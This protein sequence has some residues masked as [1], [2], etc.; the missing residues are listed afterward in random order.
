MFEEAASHLRE[1]AQDVMGC[2]LHGPP[3]RLERRPG[4]LE[5]D[6][7]IGR[8][9]PYRLAGPARISLHARMLLRGSHS[10]GEPAPWQVVVIGYQY[11]LLDADEREILAFHL[12]SEGPSQ[13]A[14]ASSALIS[15]PRASRPVR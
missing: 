14:P 11:T 12:H 9:V 6:L 15:P 1:M 3:T 2:I 10:P 13:R 8:D 5:Y 4:L 7:S